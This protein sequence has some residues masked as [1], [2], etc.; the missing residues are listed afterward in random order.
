MIVYLVL[1][2][3][4]CLYQFQAECVSLFLRFYVSNLCVFVCVNV[5]VCLCVIVCVFHM[6][7]V[8]QCVY[9]YML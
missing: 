5:F 7:C 4:M 2:F 3:F 1:L 9:I 6:F 8:I